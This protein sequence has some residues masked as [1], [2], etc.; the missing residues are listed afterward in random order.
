MKA[1]NL[2]VVS[3]ATIITIIRKGKTI[4]N[5]S[6]NEILNAHDTLVITGIHKAIDDAIKFLDGPK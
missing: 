4:F 2:R 3:G 5:P 1:I 6:G